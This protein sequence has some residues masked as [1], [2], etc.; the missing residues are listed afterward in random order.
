[1]ALSVILVNETEIK[2]KSMVKNNERIQIA[3]I[4]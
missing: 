4:R 3:L 1:M 2:Y